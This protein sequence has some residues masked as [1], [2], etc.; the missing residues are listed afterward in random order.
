MGEVSQALLDRSDERLEDGE[1]AVVGGAAFH[2]LPQMLNGGV[3]W[4]VRGELIDAEAVSVPRHELV[5]S[6][7]RVVSGSICKREKAS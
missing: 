2:R 6:D 7:R 4:G 1:V 3:V 5:G